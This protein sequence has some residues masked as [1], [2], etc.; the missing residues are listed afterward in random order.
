MKATITITLDSEE[1]SIK[2]DSNPPILMNKEEFESKPLIERQ[3]QNSLV[4]VMNLISD[5]YAK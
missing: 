4:E 3:M 1:N 2:I 5:H